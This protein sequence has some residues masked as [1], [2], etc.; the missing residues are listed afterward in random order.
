MITDVIQESLNQSNLSTDEFSELVIRL[1]GHGVITREKSK[2]ETKLYDRFVQCEELIEDYFAPLKVR[3]QHDRKF[4]FIRIFP[5]GSIVSGMPDIEDTPFNGGFRVKPSQQEIATILI[6][7]VEYEKSLR[8]GQID[9][10][11]CVLIAMESV[12]I[13]HKNLLKR[14]L[15]EV[16]GERLA[17]FQKLKQLRLIDF[18]LDE[19]ISNNDSW[20]SIQPSIT[21]FVS[22]EILSALYPIERSIRHKEP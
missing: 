11:G 5:P 21:S 8:E 18:N 20:V 14:P 13:S 4:C 10:K 15:P 17:I 2:V 7:R 6:L 22:D 9:E 19:D 3:I 16:Q 12:A 1:L